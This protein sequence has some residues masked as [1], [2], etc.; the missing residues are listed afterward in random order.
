MTRV[1]IS[2]FGRIDRDFLRADLGRRPYYGV[3]AVK[4]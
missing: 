4:K 3:V 1:A 2:G